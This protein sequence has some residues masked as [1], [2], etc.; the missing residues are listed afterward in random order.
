[1]IANRNK[2]LIDKSNGGQK[3][4]YTWVFLRVQVSLEL[5]PMKKKLYMQDQMI[6]VC[7]EIIKMIEKGMNRWSI[8]FV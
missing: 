1:M 4:Q 8:I 2:I 3:P 5:E 7:H 6:H